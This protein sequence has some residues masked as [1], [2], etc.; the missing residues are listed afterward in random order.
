MNFGCSGRISGTEK[1]QGAED[2]CDRI[3]NGKVLVSLKHVGT[4]TDL[5]EARI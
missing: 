5:G 4:N 3:T 1:T 2:L